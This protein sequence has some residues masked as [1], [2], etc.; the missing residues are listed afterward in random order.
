M[1]SLAHKEA[2]LETCFINAF[3]D[4][5]TCT[6]KPQHRTSHHYNTLLFLVF[7]W[8]PINTS[9]QLILVIESYLPIYMLKIAFLTKWLPSR[10]SKNPKLLS[11]NDMAGASERPNAT[12]HPGEPFSNQSCCPTIW[13]AAC[14]HPSI[15]TPLS[16]PS[17]HKV[18]PVPCH[19]CKI[20][21]WETPLEEDHLPLLFALKLA[22][23][24]GVRRCAIHDLVR[25]P[26]NILLLRI[27]TGP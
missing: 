26:V 24:T 13:S 4:F 2:N 25:S 7:V 5:S 6:P 23:S 14:I 18:T 9:M 22:V 20:I 17:S 19:L 12:G 8:T 10:Q 1:T 21:T 3:L 15:R 16:V 27:H 11:L